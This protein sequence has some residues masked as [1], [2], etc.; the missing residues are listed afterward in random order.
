MNEL[1]TFEATISKTH[2]LVTTG[3]YS[4]VRHPSYAGLLLMDVGIVCWFG[5]RGSF[6]RESGVLATVTGKLFFGNFAAWMLA[7]L[8]A[9]LQRATVE[10]AALREKFG[11]EWEDWARRVPYAFLPGVV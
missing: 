1:F 5:S 3:P 7:V 6:L 2:R 8:V 10:D 9:L 11:S 4:V